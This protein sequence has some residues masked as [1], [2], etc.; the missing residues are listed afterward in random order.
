M[1]LFTSSVDIYKYF[2]DGIRKYGVGSVPPERFN[3]LIN[4][5]QLNWMKSKCTTITAGQKRIDDLRAILVELDE[6]FLHGGT[7]STIIGNKFYLPTGSLY[8][9]AK[10]YWRAAA[11]RAKT[12]TATEWTQMVYEDSSQKSI[13]QIDPYEKP[14]SE[15]GKY[16]II[17]SNV[18]MNIGEGV[19]V[20]Y[21]QFEYYGYPTEISYNP[22][23]NPKGDFADEQILE[24]VDLTVQTHLERIE[25]RRFPTFAAE[26]KSK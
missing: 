2:L 18:I 14:D 24:I 3:R 21:A 9:S 17:G 4:E 23:S 10:K 22:P 13:S 5:S 7:G 16:R 15:Q 1:A 19:T 26:E 25:S 6:A 12:Q 11:L 8:G 20:Y